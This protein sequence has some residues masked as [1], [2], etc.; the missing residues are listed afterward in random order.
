MK[1]T[2][3]TEPVYLLDVKGI[4]GDARKWMGRGCIAEVEGVMLA[5]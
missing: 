1:E 3:P 2:W 4:A 5:G